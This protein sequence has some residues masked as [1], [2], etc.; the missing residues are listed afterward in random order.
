MD[1]LC[2]IYVCCFLGL[3]IF[4]GQAQSLRQQKSIVAKTGAHSVSGST[5][6]STFILG[7]STVGT[8][9]GSSLIIR[10]G[11]YPVLFNQDPTDFSMDDQEVDENVLPPGVVGVFST[12]DPEIND[13]HV[14]TL[15][16][17]EG[18]TD[19]GLFSIVGNQLQTNQPFDFEGENEN[20]YNIRIETDDE[21]GGRLQKEFT[22]IINN[23]NDQPTDL[24]IDVSAIDENLVVG[25]LVGT[26]STK[27][28]DIM[29]ASDMHGYSLAI[30]GDNG[31]FSISGNQ[32]LT[33]QSFDFETTESYTITVTTTDT[34]GSL[35]G[36]GLQFEKEMVI[37][38]NDV[39]D[40]PEA[41]EFATQPAF[42]ENLPIGTS[43]GTFTTTDEDEV[44][45]H[46]YT[47]VSGDGDSD[48]VFFEI[49]GNEILTTDILN[50]ERVEGSTFSFRVQTSDQ[51]SEVKSEM[52]NVTV[53]NIDDAPS[54]LQQVEFS[55]SEGESD[56]GVLIPIDD[57]GE[58]NNFGKL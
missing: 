43:M 22:I 41:I 17:G 58:T 40:P 36:G 16:S 31:F 33:T 32:L 49:V 27:D 30:G 24:S 39:N 10:Y 15:V 53:L 28:Q 25:T 51:E 52:F 34:G 57:D 46:T 12:D 37:S 3:G 1:F 54:G 38:V 2:R 29:S 18:D 19:N 8:S 20:T 13:T 14:Y 7:Q 42:N 6:K 55:I 11:F 23:T 44:D 26:L 35:G 56:I 45:T 50:Y 9:S 4:A 21:D 47:L 5:L 48:N